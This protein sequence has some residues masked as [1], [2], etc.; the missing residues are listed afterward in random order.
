MPLWF[1]PDRLTAV[2][3]VGAI[4]TC[5]AYA[6]SGSHS[7]L[8]WIATFGLAINW[9]GDSLDGTLTRFRNIERPRYGYYL[10]NAIDCLLG[11]PVA[12]GIGLCGYV[13]FGPFTAAATATTAKL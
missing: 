2:G 1:T 8:L 11:L 5:F 10:D 9:F 4:V 7:A 6:W 3:V 12:I 13:R